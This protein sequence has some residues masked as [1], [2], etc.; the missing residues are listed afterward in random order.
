MSVLPRRHIAKA[1]TWRII[2]SITTFIIGWAVTGDMNFG[3]AIGATDVVIKIA[4]Y[5]FHERF[6]Y[7][8]KFGVIKDGKHL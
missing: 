1:F 8:F 6:W 5:Y 2:A 7:R 3:M 4:L